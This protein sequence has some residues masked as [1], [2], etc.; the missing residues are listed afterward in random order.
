MN[1]YVRYI[2]ANDEN[3]CEM[4]GDIES[5]HIDALAIHEE[6]REM[7]KVKFRT[8][9]GRP[10]QNFTKLCFV[11]N[12]K[13]CEI[14]FE[15]IE[16]LWSLPSCQIHFF[17]HK[18]IKQ[19]LEIKIFDSQVLKISCPGENCPSL[20]TY[21]DMKYFLS[22]DYL[23]KYEKFVKRQQIN[24]DPTLKPCIVPDCEGI[25]KGTAEFPRNFCSVCNF[26]MCFLCLK[27]WHEG[28]TCEEVQIEE[29]DKWVEGKDVKDC[30]K[31]KYKIEKNLGC[32]HMTCINCHY[33][34]CWNCF[35]PWQDNH[36][37][38][39]CRAL[40]G[41]N[42]DLSYDEVSS[43]EVSSDEVSSNGILD[44][45]LLNNANFHF[46]DLIQDHIGE[47]DLDEVGNPI[48]ISNQVSIVNPDDEEDIINNIFDL[49]QEH[50]EVNSM[51][52]KTIILIIIFLPLLVSLAFLLAPAI[53][54]SLMVFR[55]DYDNEFKRWS[56]SITVFI[57]AFIFTPVI[58]VIS[59]L[60]LP[61]II[62][63]MI[64]ELK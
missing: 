4:C 26:E 46:I 62:P 35:D 63:V 64:K 25:I 48:A 1:F 54:L 32:D 34:F 42:N 23:A 60:A 59:I 33:E 58:D 50:I 7:M 15:V 27:A 20:F 43:D 39:G 38:I 41:L 5:E 49:N 37:G 51:P 11:D 30:P 19:L 6:N 36:F 52:T 56:I 28:Q 14:C 55:K 24:N 3:V 2:L 18:C 44:I 22:S 12:A 16:S 8:I 53:C 21:N 40:Q 10:S 57:A 13:S 47:V 61:C 9:E 45:D 17:C 31:C 29:F